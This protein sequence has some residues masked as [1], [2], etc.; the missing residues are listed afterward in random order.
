[1]NSFWTIALPYIMCRYIYLLWVL[2]HVINLCGDT[3]NN[4][5]EYIFLLFEDEGYFILWDG[6]HFK[7]HGFCFILG[8]LYSYSFIYITYSIP[9]VFMLYYKTLE[10][11]RLETDL[12]VL[13]IIVIIKVVFC[14]QHLVVLKPDDV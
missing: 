9:I 14:E 3:I 7:S 10:T 1:M 12:V 13:L 4:K 8:L 11:L 6:T 2:D 5:T